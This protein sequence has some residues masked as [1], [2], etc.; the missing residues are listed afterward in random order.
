MRSISLMV[1]LLSLG[2]FL[3]PPAARADDLTFD[4]TGTL[5]TPAPNNNDTVSGQ[6]TLDTATPDPLSG[7]ADSL[8]AFSFSTPFTINPFA[9]I[10]PADGWTG[11]VTTF[12]VA[13]SGQTLVDLFFRGPGGGT[14]L[15]FF[16]SD[17]STFTSNGATLVTDPVTVVNPNGGTATAHSRL[18]CTT[19]LTSP[20]CSDFAYVSAFTS[21]SATPAPEPSSL[22]LLATGLLGLAAMGW[23]KK[24]FT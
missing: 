5:V 16:Q 4:F 15:L 20:A 11:D 2:V 8:S 3:V 1:L 12:T 9:F 21:G 7:A 22:L 19:G 14:L 18:D 17:L 10:S 13:S 6:F 23:R 24:L